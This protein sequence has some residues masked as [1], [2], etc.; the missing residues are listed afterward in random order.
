M[1][2]FNGGVGQELAVDDLNGGGA[3]G[4]ADHLLVRRLWNKPILSIKKVSNQF[5]ETL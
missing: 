1:N 2:L 4:A 3:D 5:H